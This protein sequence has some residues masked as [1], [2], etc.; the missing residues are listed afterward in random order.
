[1]VDL[2][3]AIF[4]KK[5]EYV[6]LKAP[7]YEWGSCTSTPLYARMWLTSSFSSEHSLYELVR[8]GVLSCLEDTVLLQFFLISS[9]YDASPS[10]VMV[11][12]EEGNINIQFVSKYSTV[13]NSELCPTLFH[14]LSPPLY[15]EMSLMYLTT[16]MYRQIHRN[17]KRSLMFY[18]HSAE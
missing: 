13:T 10:S 9:S 12:G 18:V 11:H 8:T 14:C 7:C 15:K 6:F 3:G 17:L 16:L 1:M 5:T 4:F 2:P